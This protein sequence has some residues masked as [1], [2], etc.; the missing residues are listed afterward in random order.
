MI[1]PVSSGNPI[2]P[3]AHLATWARAWAGGASINSD[4]LRRNV[5][6]SLPERVSGQYG[7]A[8]WGI[9]AQALRPPGWARGAWYAPRSSQG[10]CH[11]CSC[12]L[13]A[14]LP[15]RGR[16]RRAGPIGPAPRSAG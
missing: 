11:A 8:T 5:E 16:R 2:I 12:Q 13:A 3:T 1:T 4:E 15:R 7:G 14:L 10:D 6:A 9:T